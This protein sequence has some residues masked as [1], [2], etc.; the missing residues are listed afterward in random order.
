M[1]YPFLDANARSELLVYTLLPDL[2]IILL[3]YFAI[4]G[5]APQ[6]IMKKLSPPPQNFSLKL[7]HITKK[8]QQEPKSRFKQ[9]EY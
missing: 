4:V 2:G 5:P 8:K 1:F 3:T 7:T 6:N 9:Q